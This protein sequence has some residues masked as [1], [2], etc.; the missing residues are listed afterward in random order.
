MTSQ[1]ILISPRLQYSMASHPGNQD[2]PCRCTLQTGPSWHITQH[3]YCHLSWANDN[4][5]L[6]SSPDPTYQVFIT[7]RPPSNWKSTKGI[8]FICLLLSNG[9]EVQKRS[10]LLQR[11]YVHPTRVHVYVKWQYFHKHPPLP[12]HVSA[13]FGRICHTL[14]PP[15]PLPHYKHLPCLLI[16]HSY[17][18]LLYFPTYYPLSS[19][20]PS[21][22]LSSLMPP[23]STW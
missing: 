7:I 5:C 16:S 21:M 1:M 23:H 20:L 19:S 10:P 15:P 2:G 3:W 18:L 4:Q 9:L 14:V 8:I 22:S 17:A 12:A 13:W 11:M 6:R